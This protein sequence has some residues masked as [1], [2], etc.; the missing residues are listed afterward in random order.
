MKINDIL[1]Q[2]SLTGWN[3]RAWTFFVLSIISMLIA[4]IVIFMS[5]A[6]SFMPLWLVPT[7]II[8]LLMF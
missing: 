6:D 2:L 7:T 5:S 4:I 1:V 8:F 3:F